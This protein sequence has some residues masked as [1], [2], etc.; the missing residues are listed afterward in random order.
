MRADLR[1]NSNVFGECPYDYDFSK[2]SNTIELEFLKR[3]GI[4]QTTTTR[5]KYNIEMYDYFFKLYLLNDVIKNKF[6]G[7][8]T[9]L[10]S[11]MSAMISIDFYRLLG[12]DNDLNIDKFR[13]L[14]SQN[15]SLFSHNIIDNVLKSIRETMKHAKNLYT[16]FFADSR[17]K[18]FAHSGKILLNDKNVNDIVSN[19]NTKIMNELLK[20]IIDIL[21]RIWMAYNNHNLCFVLT[22]G[23]DYK[24]LTKSLCT[25][26]GDTK[27]V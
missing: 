17:H 20:Q 12:D 10:L 2:I 9:I 13:N 21:N 6:Q 3:M 7:F 27:F 19:I 22:K 18:I 24:E 14:C 5:L 1:Y 4:L 16:Q 8:F 26:Y 15:P 23:G 25:R 11:N